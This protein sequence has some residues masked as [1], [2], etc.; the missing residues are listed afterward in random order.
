MGLL[1][2]V[3]DYI[4]VIEFGRLI[5]QGTPAQI[6]SDDR[7]IAAYLGESARKDVDE[8]KSALAQTEPGGQGET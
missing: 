2:G 5:A 3:C 6:R 1:L 4:Y 8:A 7:V